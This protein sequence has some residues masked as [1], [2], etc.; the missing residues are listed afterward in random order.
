VSP[1]IEVPPFEFPGIRPREV[2]V[3]VSLIKTLSILGFA[4]GPLVTGVV[5]QLA[6]SLQMG[7]LVLCLLTGTSIMAGWC[8]PRCANNTEVLGHTEQRV[9]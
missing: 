4:L 8:Y 9:P 7:L 6:G 3:V 1:V 5:A 2:A